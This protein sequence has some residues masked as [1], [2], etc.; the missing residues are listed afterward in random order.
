MPERRPRSLWL[1]VFAVNQLLGA[2]LARSLGGDEAGREFAVYSA[3]QA[4]GPTTTTEFA[5][6]LG[7]PLT[8]ASDRLNRMVDRGHATRDVNPADRR[9]HLFALTEEG[10]RVTRAHMPRFREVAAR[11]GRR[12][13]LPSDEIK[14][15]LEALED[16]LR[17]ELEEIEDKHAPKP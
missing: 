12:L 15:G 13:A 1:D 2:V 9:S 4:L 17:R 10:R 7:L 16:A 11:L 14:A 3:L 8:T 5:R 6:F